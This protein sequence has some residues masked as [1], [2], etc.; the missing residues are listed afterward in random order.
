MSEG[1]LIGSVRTLI[2]WR[3]DVVFRR[4]DEAL[5]GEG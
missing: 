3:L 2:L 4:N 5:E 1:H